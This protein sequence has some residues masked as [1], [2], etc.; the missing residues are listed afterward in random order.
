MSNYGR[1]GDERYVR[2]ITAWEQ[3]R[4]LYTRVPITLEQQQKAE[5]G[6]FLYGD[7][8]MLN[9]AKSKITLGHVVLGLIVFR[10]WQTR[11]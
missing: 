7:P 2:Q 4:V 9:K 5:A 1:E 11:N 10:L 8:S 6:K 3:P